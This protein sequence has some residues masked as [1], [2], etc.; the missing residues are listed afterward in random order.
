MGISKDSIESLKL[1]SKISDF[2]LSSTTGKIRGNK[3]MALCPFHGEKT[4]SMSFTDEE[5]LFHCFV[6]SKCRII[7]ILEQ[8]FKVI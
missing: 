6:V 4:A 3:G 5:N 8:N 7:D 2:I 1:K